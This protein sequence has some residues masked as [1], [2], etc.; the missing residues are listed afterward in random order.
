MKDDSWKGSGKKINGIDLGTTYSAIAV[1]NDYGVPEIVPNVDGH[2]STPSVIFFDDGKITVGLEA[3]QKAKDHPDSLVN[4]V[5]RSMGEAHYRFSYQ[6]KNFSAEELSSFILRKL[7][8]DAE[9][10]TGEKITDVVITC[11]A[12]F[13]INER[14]ATRLAGE[15]AGLNVRQIINEPTA[16]AIAYGSVGLEQPHVVLVYDLGGGTFDITMIDIQQESIRVI[17]T[18]GDH[19]LGGK[20]WDDR[21]LM[22]VAEQISE[23]SGQDVLDDNQAW[24]DL[25]YQAEMAKITLSGSPTAMISLPF[26]GE[27][28][29]VSI[30]LAAFE[31]MTKD[32]LER[33][34]SLTREMLEN[35]K[36]KGYEKFDEIILVGGST[37]MPKVAKILQ[38]KFGLEPRLFHPDE[39]VAKGA[40]IF[41]WKLFLKDKMVARIIE[42]KK[43]KEEAVERPDEDIQIDIVF[44]SNNFEKAARIAAVK[45]DKDALDLGQLTEDTQLDLDMTSQSPKQRALQETISQE[46]LNRDL[47]VSFIDFEEAARAVANATG[48]TVP[49]VKKSMFEIQDVVSKSFGIVARN[50]KDEEGV[51][52]VV[53]RNSPVPVTTK[54][55]FFTAVPNQK[56]IHIRIMESETHRDWIKIESA[57]EIGDAW[58]RL[59]KGLPPKVPVDIS[60]SLNREGRLE[61][62]ATEKAEGRK[63]E[64]TISTTSVIS[65]EELEE[66]KARSTSLCIS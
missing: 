17:G 18:G 42:G 16:A 61:I 30:T 41:G 24:T 57:V 55:T 58:L 38:R 1:V 33:T 53:T 52:I 27:T 28:Y 31:Q 19:N 48:Y 37:R 29:Q 5:K 54:K 4:F 66:A 47:G 50:T 62:T 44:L 45:K 15:I 64:L 26:K 49:A 11:P 25:Q 34:V 65:G 63:V 14:E 51:S 10:Q 9:K 13:G 3:I 56:M 32:L 40:A 7:V 12:Y 39:A 43:A 23:K 2:R 36:E 22:Y 8:Q 35:A 6:D 46:D 21:I 20:D 59:P 60:F